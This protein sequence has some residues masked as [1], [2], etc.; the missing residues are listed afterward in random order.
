MF[1]PKIERNFLCNVAENKYLVAACRSK[2][3]LLSQLTTSYN[4]EP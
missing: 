3:P 1:M 2:T 4:Q